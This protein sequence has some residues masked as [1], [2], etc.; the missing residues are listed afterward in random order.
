MRNRVVRVPPSFFLV[1]SL[2]LWAPTRAAAQADSEID[3]VAAFP[4]NFHVVL[5]NE[6]VRVVEYALAPG[7]RDGWHT[8]PPKVSVVLEGGTLRITP[9]DGAS[10]LAESTPGS[11]SWMDSVG[12]HY[13]ENVGETTVRILLVEVKSAAER[14]EG[15]R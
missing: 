3:A 9:R 5:E 15:E 8:H 13:T 1:L 11:A 4:Q 7:E 6:H 14:T 2:I 12:E 10:F